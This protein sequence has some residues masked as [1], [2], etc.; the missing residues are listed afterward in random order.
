M[1]MKIY[2]LMT[3]IT[4]PLSMIS[5]MVP[6]ANGNDSFAQS[7]FPDSREL[8]GSQGELTSD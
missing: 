5:K 7:D 6:N 8:E 4:N 2:S 3:A 1:I